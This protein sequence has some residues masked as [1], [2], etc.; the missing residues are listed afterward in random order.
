MLF[1]SIALALSVAP[2]ASSVPYPIATVVPAPKAKDPVSCQL[3][4][5]IWSRI[6]KRICA[7]ESWWEAIA[8][9]QQKDV[10]DTLRKVTN[11]SGGA[12]MFAK[13]P[14]N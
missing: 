8:E 13:D 10:R 12:G 1:A 4:Y 2:T 6:P 9:V 3:Y 7:P 14:G 11:T 5:R